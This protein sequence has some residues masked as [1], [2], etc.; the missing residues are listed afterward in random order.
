MVEKRESTRTVNKNEFVLSHSDILDLMRDAA[1]GLSPSDDENIYLYVRKANDSEINLNLRP[2]Y[3]T[4]KIVF[5]FYTVTD[6]E[7]DDTLTDVDV[8]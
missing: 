7:A 6:V 8:S 1:V 3:E 2:L 4:D 5:R